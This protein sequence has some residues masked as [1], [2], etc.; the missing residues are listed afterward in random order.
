M[1]GMKWPSQDVVSI[2]DLARIS[3]LNEIFLDIVMS[4]EEKANQFIN[5]VIK[6]LSDENS[7]TNQG[8]G[9]KIINNIFR[10]KSGQMVNLK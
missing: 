7:K 3:L 6:F 1:L 4:N 8:L 9:L 10:G 5:V 2:L